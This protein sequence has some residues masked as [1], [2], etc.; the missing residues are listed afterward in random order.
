M[1]YPEVI[2][3]HTGVASIVQA[4][5][6]T[7][8]AELVAKIRSTH[9]PEGIDHAVASGG[10]SSKLCTSVDIVG[11]ADAHTEDTLHGEAGTIAEAYAVTIV[12]H[13]KHTAHNGVDGHTLD[14]ASGVVV[15]DVVAS[16]VTLRTTGVVVLNAIVLIAE[17][18]SSH[19]GFQGTIE[20]NSLKLGNAKIELV[21]SVLQHANTGAEGI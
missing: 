6:R 5:H 10:V 8:T 1:D 3:H 2:Q 17:R 4:V 9:A 12:G 18:L 21:N 13:G 16:V 11:N 15:V 7:G 19:A 14:R 20:G